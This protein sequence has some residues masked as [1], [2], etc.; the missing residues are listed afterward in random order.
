[1]RICARALLA[2]TVT[3]IT[4]AVFAQPAAPAEPPAEPPVTPKPI[5]LDDPMLDDVP[6]APKTLTSWRQAL[7]L[8]S[9]E[10]ADYSISL[11][12]IERARGDE[13]RALAGTLPTLTGTGNVTLHII[14]SEITSLDFD[15]GT[16]TT[17]TVPSSPTA[18]ASLS[19]RQPLIAPRVWYGIGTA[20]KVTEAAEAS[21]E[22]TQRRLVGRVASA[23]VAV[24]TAERIAETNRVG[25]RAALERLALQKRRLEL[26]SGTTLDVVRFEQDVV[27]ARAT[28]IQGDEDLRRSREA[29]GLA[30]GSVE[31][32]GVSREISIN[33][34]EATIGKICKSDSLDSRADIR[35]LTIQREIAE[36]SVTDADLLYSPTADLSSTFTYSSEDLIG[37]KNYSWNI[38]GLLTI[39][40][41]DGGARYG[42]HRSA[43]ATVRQQEERLDAAKRSARVEVTQAQRAVTVAKN[44]LTVAQR[45]RDL[46]AETD[47]LAQRAF[48][49]GAVTSFDLVDAS[50][51]LREAELSLAV[52]ELEL[53]RAKI[54]S[55]LAT[56]S[57]TTQ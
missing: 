17:I 38:Q 24:V 47:R 30:L 3:A 25:L 22:D 54:A 8:S 11:F 44:A 35:A 18:S 40:I 21:A 46:A 20:E 51:R 37:N 36:R 13:R 41:W 29:L 32:Y 50:R 16:P 34:I 42:I 14:R 52:R 1:M 15:T 19:L 28:L 49:A 10:D 6:D 12:E 55:V 33:E 5:A 57:C 31:P 2:L 43:V 48:E 39:P 56:A 7:A 9:A 26:G 53:V 45:A 27:A 4:G 23:I